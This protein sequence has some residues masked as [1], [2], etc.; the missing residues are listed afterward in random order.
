MH[1]TKQC[2][3][4]KEIEEYDGYSNHT[5]NSKQQFDQIWLVDVSFFTNNTTSATNMCYNKRCNPHLGVDYF[6]SIID[7]A[8]K[9]AQV[10]SHYA[11]YSC[12][13][14]G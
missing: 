1:T 10:K 3:R 9:S 4:E 12:V 5:Y 2:I 13:S 6:N 11:Q 8:K 14:P 7:S